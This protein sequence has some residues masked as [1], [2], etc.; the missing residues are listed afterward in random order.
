MPGGRF[1]R[2]EQRPDG[3]A[4]FCRYHEKDRWYEVEIMT[5]VEGALDLSQRLEVDEQM[6]E[7]FI[8]S[9]EHDKC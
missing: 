6:R 1:T 2:F 7:D 8:T 9:A 5:D 4:V 3:Y